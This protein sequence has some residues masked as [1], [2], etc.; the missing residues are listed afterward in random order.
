[1]VTLL[2]VGHP[3]A[4]RA[5]VRA[6]GAEIVEDVA[7]PDHARHTAASMRRV[8]EAA[9]SCD[10]IVMTAKDWVKA[11][12]VLDSTNWPVPVVVPRLEMDVFAGG[13][14]LVTIVLASVTAGSD[15]RA[16]TP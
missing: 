9:S 4:V 8:L 5:Q 16:P 7:A 3:G 12:N 13:D 1:V 15:E 14:E 2:G 10:A 11:G 6:A